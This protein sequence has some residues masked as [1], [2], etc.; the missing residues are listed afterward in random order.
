MLESW[1]K[2]ARKQLEGRLD[3]KFGNRPEA[4]FD[5][6]PCFAATRVI[7]KVGG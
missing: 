7:L 1:S 6:G 4:A 5:R 3:F 2:T